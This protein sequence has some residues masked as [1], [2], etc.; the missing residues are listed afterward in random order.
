MIVDIVIDLFYI[1]FSI[2]L[3]FSAPILTAVFTINRSSI[4]VTYLQRKIA[5][6]SQ[7]PSSTVN[8]LLLLCQ[9]NT[10]LLEFSYSCFGFSFSLNCYLA[11]VSLTRGDK[12]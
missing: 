10:G 8:E 11:K 12:N 1:A 5:L 6:N 2:I 4:R 3:S 9:T 7:N